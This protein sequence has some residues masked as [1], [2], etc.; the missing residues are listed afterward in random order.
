M[1]PSPSPSPLEPY[2]ELPVLGTNHIISTVQYLNDY[3]WHDAFGMICA[4]GDVMHITS[5]K[6]PSLHLLPDI[7]QLF[8]AIMHHHAYGVD[9][10]VDHAINR[11]LHLTVQTCQ[12]ARETQPRMN[13]HGGIRW[14]TPAEIELRKQIQFYRTF[15][16]YLE[17]Y[18]MSLKSDR[19]LE[20]IRNILQKLSP[21]VNN[22]T[23]W[24]PVI[25]PRDIRQDMQGVGAN[26]T[27]AKPPRRRSQRLRSHH[28]TPELEP[29]APNSRQQRRPPRPRR[30]KVSPPQQQLPT[31][32]IQADDPTCFS[33]YMTD[34]YI[35][36]LLTPL[37]QFLA[38]SGSPR[39][40]KVTDCREQQE[41]EPTQLS[42]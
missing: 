40:H 13:P 34:D 4:I 10:Q 15:C 2:L 7:N 41:E 42:L 22:L 39:P 6:H 11:L 19:S 1:S 17:N 14:M 3:R 25:P 32:P 9:H 8:T 29:C 12:D 38:P 20:T 35:P 5:A 26:N 33:T 24:V 28:S 31:P 27:P 37:T 18:S 30:A 36:S 21:T 23:G 16:R